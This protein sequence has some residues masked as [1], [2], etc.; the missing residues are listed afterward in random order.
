MI[1][2]SS[3]NLL[4]LLILLLCSPLK[5]EDKIDIWSNKK[6]DLSEQQIIRP[7]KEKKKTI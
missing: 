3:K 4:S 7:E 2:K 1:L 5:G 6:K